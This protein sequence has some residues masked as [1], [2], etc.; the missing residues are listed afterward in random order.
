MSIIG[1]IKSS[2]KHDGMLN[3][4]ILINLAVF[5]VYSLIRTI[6]F[7]AGHGIDEQIAHNLAVPADLHELLLHPWTPITY[8]FFHEGFLHILFNI[9]WLYWFGKIFIEF[10]THRQL[11]WV[12]LLGG[13]S[14]AFVYILI[15][16]VLPVFNTSTIAVGASAAIMAIVFAV[17]TL[18]PN[19]QI[20]LAFIGTLRLKYLALITVLLDLITIPM[21]NAGGHIAHIGGAIFGVIF[22]VMRPK[23]IDITKPFGSIKKEKKKKRKTK[24]KVSHQQYETDWEYN[25]RKASE[26]KEIDAILDKISRSGYASLT[27][28]EKNKLFKMKGKNN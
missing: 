7:L 24:M 13:L 16:N 23:N 1:E 8:M 25:A 19:I 21:G 10:L 26:Q 5:V 12:Y 9:L 15:Y 28:N 17:A 14:G 27:E 18:Q 11:L 6:G 3:R 4:L 2:F 20:R 22:A